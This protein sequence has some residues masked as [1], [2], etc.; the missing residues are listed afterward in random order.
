[1]RKTYIK[2][3]AKLLVRTGLA[4]HKGQTVI[5]QANVDQ[6]DFVALVSEEC[7]KAGARK[8]IVRWSSQKVNRVAFKKESAKSLSEVLPFEIEEAKWKAEELPA[9]LWID[10]DDPD[11]NKGIDAG[12]SAAVRSA[13]YKVLGKYREAMENRYQWC[14]AGAPSPAWAK[15]VFPGEK[16]S[17]AMEKLWQAILLTSRAEDGKGIER[18]A[19]HDEELKRRCAYLNSLRLKKL[20]YS[21]SNGTDLTVGLIPGVRFLGGGERIIGGD[22]EFQPNIPTEECFTS[23]KKGEA[24]GVVYSAKPLV[25]NGQVIRNFHLVFRQGKAVEAY[26]EEG[27]ETLR[28]ILSLDEGS[29]YLG[30]CALVPFDSPINNTGLLFYNTLYDENACCHLALGQGF[31]ELYPDFEK[32]SEEEL[33]GFGINHSLSHVDFMIGSQDLRIV[34]TKE[35]GEEVEIFKDGNWAFDF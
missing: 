21:S 32:Y 17:A 20:H 19:K 7:Y 1:M 30:E 14:I 24:E 12:K 34:G 26:A 29:A 16:K 15:K 6:E 31:Y 22:F 9:F 2:E 4:L 27:E 13:R 10:S 25:Y 18:W 5:V 8:V 11:G 35:S 23:P 3:Y 33:K 28:S